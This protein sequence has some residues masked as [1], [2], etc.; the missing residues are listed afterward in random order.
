[1]SKAEELEKAF[2]DRLSKM[3][4]QAN[5]MGRYIVF[6]THRFVQANEEKGNI[7]IL[8]NDPRFDEQELIGLCID[9][10]MDYY[11]QTDRKVKGDKMLLGAS[12]VLKKL[13][14]E[15]LPNR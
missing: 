3:Q 12:L 1:M 9:M 10:I 8:P 5:K 2:A 4:A 15:G 6:Y 11:E 7:L 13:Y 14:K